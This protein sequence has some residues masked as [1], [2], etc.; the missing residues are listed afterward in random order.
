MFSLSKINSA[1]ENICIKTY[2]SKKSI[3]KSKQYDC[4]DHRKNRGGSFSIGSI[5]SILLLQI[6]LLSIPQQ[7]LS[8]QIKQYTNYRRYLTIS[9]NDFS[10]NFIFKSHQIH[11]SRN[12]I[13]ISNELANTEKPSSKESLMHLFEQSS[14]LYVCPI[15]LSLLTKK[16]KLFGL[17]KEDY[18]FEPEF[19][20]KYTKK[21]NIYYDFTIPAEKKRKFRFTQDFFQNPI[22]SSVYERGYRQN[23]ETIG[24]PGIEKEF[25]EVKQFFSSVNASTVLDI[26]C[27]SGFMTRNLLKSKL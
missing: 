15:T 4:S 10:K 3:S 18:F 9:P 20:N 22:I 26:S 16:L 8:Y 24:F 7:I 1:L 11:T 14:D 19:K 17:V 5:C 2:F 6:V 23:F 21:D 25:E 13:S 12:V 27:G